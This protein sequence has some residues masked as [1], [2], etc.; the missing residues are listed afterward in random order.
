MTSHRW[1][2]NRQL[3]LLVWLLFCSTLQAQT[4]ACFSA[5]PLNSQAITA[6]GSTPLTLSEQQNLLKLLEKLNGSW[7]GKT[8][9]FFCSSS[10]NK[11]ERTEDNYDLLA[12]SK[13]EREKRAGNNA[14]FDLDATLE[15]DNK[16][17]LH[18]TLQ[19]TLHDGVLYSGSSKTNPVVVSDL[20]S[21]SVTLIEATRQRLKSGGSTPRIIERH[22]HITNARRIEIQHRYYTQG[23]LN[24]YSHWFMRR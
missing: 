9:G 6:S 24:S 14:R 12:D 7:D 11:A 16:Y 8:A 10:K 19:Y 23:Q 13:L 3:I 15:S 22:I 17:P 4:S 20:R 1:P 21:N 18:E 5:A 2:H